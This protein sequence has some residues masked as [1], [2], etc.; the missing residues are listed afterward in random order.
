MIT[1][2]PIIIPNNK[3]SDGTYPVKIRVYFNGKSRRLPTT[4]VCH[5]SDITRT[6]RKSV[7]IKKDAGVRDKAKVL[8]DK[9]RAIVGKYTMIELEGKDVDWVVKKIKDGLSDKDF[10]LDFFE[11]AEKFIICKQP[12]TRNAY[13]RALNAFE[14]FLGKRSIDINSINKMMIIEFMEFIDAEKKMRWDRK[15]KTIIESKVE[16]IPKAASSLLVMKLQ[17]IFE[18]A[19]DRYND[20]DDEKI[21]IPRSPFSSIKKVFPVGDQ[22]QEALSKDVM[23]Q[24]ILA[25][26]D[27]ENVRVALDTFIVSF[28]LMG[29][30]LADLYYA[31]PFKG[32]EW[33]Y[34]RKKITSRKAEMRV[35]IPPQILPHINR[36]K[37][38]KDKSLWLPALHEF[39]KTKHYCNQRLNICLRRWQSDINSEDFTMYAARHSWAQYARDLGYDLAS[40]NECL[41]HK[42]N[43]EM[44]RIYASLTWEQ[45]NEINQK[46]IDSFVWF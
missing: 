36:L 15:T 24:I 43:L 19:K 20:E 5:P 39:G 26:T 3:R 17:H 2:E 18:A 12:N 31:T 37:N 11:W 44:G 16:R 4:W 42:D 10:H 45:K 35:K 38:G 13:T 21:N 1:F 41:C 9:M 7:K 27:D 14:R 23:Q 46:V 32:N 28:A 8:I 34:D 22:A 6:K 25:H 33:V 29:A 40:V 30:N